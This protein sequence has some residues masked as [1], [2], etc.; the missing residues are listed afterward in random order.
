MTYWEVNTPAL[1]R[2]RGIADEALLG[3]KG[4]FREVRGIVTISCGSRN[5]GATYAPAERLDITIL[6]QSQASFLVPGQ[7]TLAGECPSCAFRQWVTGDR[8]RS[9]APYVTEEIDDDV[10]VIR[11]PDLEGLVVIPRQHIS[12]INGLSVP[13]RANLLAAL[14]RVAQSV[15]E[16][17]PGS[18]TRIVVMTDAPATEGHV[19]FHVTPRG[20]RIR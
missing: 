13:R 6:E 18:A 20:L 17:N 3:S 15:Q 14:R 16:R 12:G 10:V 4:V 2:T 1:I 7:D 9:V 8:T 11:E 19:C 5:T